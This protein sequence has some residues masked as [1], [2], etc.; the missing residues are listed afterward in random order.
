MRLYKACQRPLQYCP[1]HITLYGVFCCMTFFPE[2]WSDEALADVT[3]RGGHAPRVVAARPR[4]S[5]FE[6]LIHQYKPTVC[7][8]FSPRCMI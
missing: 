8:F 4:K 5:A 3:D 2:E 1:K 7:P 6:I